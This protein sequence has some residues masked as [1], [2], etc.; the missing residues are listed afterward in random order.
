M[1]YSKYYSDGWK[2]NEEGGTPITAAALNNM[3]NGIKHCDEQLT[4]NLTKGTPALTHYLQAYGSSAYKALV[5]DVAKC[6]INDYKGLS[7][8]GTAQS[9]KSAL[10]SLNSENFQSQVTFAEGESPAHAHFY[11]AG[12]I[13]YV[14]YQGTAKTHSANDA[15]FTLPA[16]YRPA[17]QT[18]A[19]FSKNA[20]A[21]GT[22]LINTDGSVKVAMISDATTPGRIYFNAV[23]V[24]S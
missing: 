5:S 22:I 18:Y 19:I 13:C 1:A 16:G 14:Y 12:K 7:L 2:D 20:N 24:T 15:L 23:Y 9:V 3:E 21:Y 10:D 11:K 8:A 6:I 4:E 17:T